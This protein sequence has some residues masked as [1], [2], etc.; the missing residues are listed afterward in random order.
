MERSILNLFEVP[1]QDWPWKEEGR[2]GKLQAGWSGP[3]KYKFNSNHLAHL[4]VTF[5][6][7]HY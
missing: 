1:F 7:D 5:T 6:V 2:P 3:P 4:I